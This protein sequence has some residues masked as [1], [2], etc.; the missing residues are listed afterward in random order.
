MLGTDK[1]F[2]KLTRKYKLMQAHNSLIKTGRYIEAKLIMELLTDGKICIGLSNA[3]NT[4]EHLTEEIGCHI[5]YGRSFNT[6]TIYA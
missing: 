1:Y 6:A 3:D 2:D 5:S 4:V